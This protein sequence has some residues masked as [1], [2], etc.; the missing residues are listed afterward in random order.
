MCVP[1]PC[2]SVAIGLSYLEG[3]AGSRRN[4]GIVEQNLPARFHANVFIR[5]C[6]D[7]E[8][9]ASTRVIWMCRETLEAMTQLRRGQRGICDNHRPRLWLN[10][11]KSI[12]SQS[13]IWGV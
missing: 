2:L 5:L 13:C 3:G 12:E 4:G 1:V 11:A 6:V 8:G 10:V 9:R 7:C